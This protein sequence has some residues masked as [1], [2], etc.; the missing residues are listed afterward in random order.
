MDDRQVEGLMKS[1][2]DIDF[3]V[4]VERPPIVQQ[5]S[6]L[7]AVECHFEMIETIYGWYSEHFTIRWMLAL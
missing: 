6:I 4:V 3:D 7:C 5:Y 2:D 1:D